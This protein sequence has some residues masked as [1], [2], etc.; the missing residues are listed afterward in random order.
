MDRR[1]A[2]PGMKIRVPIPLEALDRFEPMPRRYEASSSESKF[3]L[4]DLSEQF[5][6]AYDL[7]SLVFDAPVATGRRT[8]P[9]PSGEFRITAFHRFHRSSLYTVEGTSR[10][11]PMYYGLRFLTTLAGVTYWIHGR[12][13][14]SS[15][16]CPHRAGD[17]SSFQVVRFTYAVNS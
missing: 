9:T 4:I 6:G 17:V 3:L 5:V 2:H 1:H 11:Y 8:H 13:Y 10:P 7:G 16:R 14:S 15:E 12:T